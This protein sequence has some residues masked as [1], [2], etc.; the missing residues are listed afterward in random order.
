MATFATTAVRTSN[1]TRFIE[2]SE[3]LYPGNSDAST[4]TATSFSAA[5]TTTTIILLQPSIIL[6]LILPTSTLPGLLQIKNH[7]LI[8]FLYIFTRCSIED[9]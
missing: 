8:R 5:A 9:K 6:L 1:P 7:F 4:T 3:Y 2:V